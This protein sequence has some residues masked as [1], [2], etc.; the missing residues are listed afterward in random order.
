M[1]QSSLFQCMHRTAQWSSGMILALGRA[2]RCANCSYVDLTCERPRFRLSAE[3]S[4]FL[5]LLLL[6]VSPGDVPPKAFFLFFLSFSFKQ[7][8]KKKKSF[9]GYI[10]QGGIHFRVVVVVVLVLYYM[11]KSYL[12]YCS[13]VLEPCRQR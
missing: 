10:P 1:Q 6:F 12:Y 5:L 7:K 3:P 2:K 11:V 4:S 8:K 13:L 9:W